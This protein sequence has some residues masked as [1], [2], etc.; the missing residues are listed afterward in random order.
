MG[1]LIA[2]FAELKFF[3]IMFIIIV[4]MASIMTRNSVKKVLFFAFGAVALI[5][6]STLLSSLYDY[7]TDFMSFEKMWDMLFNPHYASEEDIGRLSAIP[8]ISERFLKTIPE[9]LFGMGLGNADYSSVA[10]FNTD[11]FDTYRNTHYMLMMYS[12]LYIETGILGLILYVSFFIISLGVTLKI[13]KAKLADEAAC[14]LSIIFG[15]ICYILLIYN[16]E[17]RKEIG[18]FAFFVLSLPFISMG[19]VKHKN[20]LKD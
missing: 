18:Y 7:F 15:V 1:L 8:V 14:Q 10:I 5:L 9:R 11:F 12:F 19:V 3:F 2:A 6:F 13:Y 17:L 4:V 16:V 20:E